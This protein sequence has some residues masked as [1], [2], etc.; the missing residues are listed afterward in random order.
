MEYELLKKKL[1][2]KENGIAVTAAVIGVTECE[3]E[4]KLEGKIPLYAHEADAICKHLRI[5]SLDDRLSFFYPERP[6]SGTKQKNAKEICCEE[7]KMSSQMR[8]ETK[9]KGVVK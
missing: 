1:S 3:L 4:L 8:S 5:K 2:E 7:T 9:E 6:K